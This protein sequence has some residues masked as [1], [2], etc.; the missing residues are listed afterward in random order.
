MELTNAINAQLGDAYNAIGDNT[1]SD[2]SYELVLKLDPLND[3]VLNN[4]S[5]FLSLRKQKLD[6]A[7]Q[8]STKLVERNPDSATFLDTHAWVLYVMKDYAKARTFLEKAL[9]GDPA[10]VSGTVIEHYGDVLFQIGE[11]D[12]AIEQWKR[13][14]AKGGASDQLEKKITTGNLHE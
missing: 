5:Y 9:A 2:E 4:Y 7:L 11:R 1:K 3:Y 12:K 10:G 13:A 8:L 14:K 6:R